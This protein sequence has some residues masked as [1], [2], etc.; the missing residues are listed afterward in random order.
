VELEPALQAEVF[1]HILEVIRFSGSAMEQAPATY[2]QLGEEDRRNV[3][4]SNLNSHYRGQAS[5]EAFN[6][7]GH[8]DILISH[9]N[10]NL[11]IAECKIWH[12]RQSLTDAIDQL[13]SYTAWRDTKTALVV[14]VGEKRFGEITK[15]A[16]EALAAHP[17]FK[18][19]QGEPG[20]SE[21]R[22]TMTWP[23]DPDRE[24][25]LALTLF[26]IPTE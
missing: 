25:D 7:A 3:I 8:T 12:G 26:H 19:W 1:D 9:E 6:R 20:E 17:Q 16:R 10:K 4:V 22:A 14:F 15:R 18:E 13:F 2:A 21:F 24:I 5:A 11:F 23:D